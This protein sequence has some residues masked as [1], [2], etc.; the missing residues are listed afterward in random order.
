[1]KTVL[2]KGVTAGVGTFLRG[3]GQAPYSLFF[4]AIGSD[5]WHRP[6]PPPGIESPT[7]S[8]GLTFSSVQ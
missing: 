8:S 3:G 7:R 4:E 6:W 1:M 2:E 5:T